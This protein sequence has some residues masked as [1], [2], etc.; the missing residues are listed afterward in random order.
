[1]LFTGAWAIDN[2]TVGGPGAPT[3]GGDPAGGWVPLNGTGIPAGDPTNGSVKDSFLLP[4]GTPRWPESVHYSVEEN[5]YQAL[6]DAMNAKGMGP[7]W[8]NTHTIEKGPFFFWTYFNVVFRPHL[9][10][11]RAGFPR[12]RRH[13]AQ[14][15]QDEADR[16][17]LPRQAAGELLQPAT[18]QAAVR[19][20]LRPLRITPAPQARAELPRQVR[21]RARPADQRLEGRRV[22][23]DQ[24]QRRLSERHPLLHRLVGVPRQRRRRLR[25]AGAH[26]AGID[27]HHLPAEPERESVHDLP[28][29]LRPPGR[30]L[31]LR[32]SG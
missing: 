27:G 20:H 5:D 4:S 24:H 32:R 16:R 8:I 25:S 1:M 6:Y 28:E 9:G 10:R 29:G 30:H 7:A 31:L 2:D 3:G 17:R 19:R 11:R 15:P 22:R 14:C 12:P 21:R 26:R 13:P 18:G 23:A